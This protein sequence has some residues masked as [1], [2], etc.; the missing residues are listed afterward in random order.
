MDPK[1]AGPN[2]ARLVGHRDDR[3]SVR[4]LTVVLYRF[5]SW[6]AVVTRRDRRAVQSSS[7]PEE[8]LRIYFVKGNTGYLYHGCGDGESS[9]QIEQ[10][11]LDALSQLWSC[12]P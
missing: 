7:I 3:A 5:R 6:S 9:G 4:T 8:I 10:S 2:T 1:I 12:S 11:F